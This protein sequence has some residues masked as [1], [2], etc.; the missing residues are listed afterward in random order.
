MPQ[1]AYQG[2]PH[3]TQQDATFPEELYSD[4]ELKFHR[5]QAMI[6]SLASL[7]KGLVSI[8]KWEQ[9]LVQGQEVTVRLTEVLPLMGMKHPAS[10]RQKF[11]HAQSI[12][13]RCK[14]WLWK[15]IR[16]QVIIRFSQVVFHNYLA[17]LE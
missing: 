3:S 15:D 5:A 1:P 14:L 17:A 13:S 16:E 9:Q 7:N 10:V 6:E 11:A 4:R 8:A 12:R 2:Q